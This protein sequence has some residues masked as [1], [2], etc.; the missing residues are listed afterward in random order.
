MFR[1]SWCNCYCD[2]TLLWLPATPPNEVPGT[3]EARLAAKERYAQRKNIA[4]LTVKRKILAKHNM[5]P[6][7]VAELV[8]V[9]GVE[10]SEMKIYKEKIKFPVP[11][12]ELDPEAHNGFEIDLKRHIIDCMYTKWARLVIFERDTLQALLMESLKKPDYKLEASIHFSSRHG[13]QKTLDVL[14]LVKEWSILY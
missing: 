8:S 13:A 9:F 12:F 7:F 4:V 11:C 6:L 1:N 5:I 14:G 10:Q 2:H 3:I